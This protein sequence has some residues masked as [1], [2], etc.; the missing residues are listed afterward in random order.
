[1]TGPADRAY[2]AYREVR[3]AVLRIKAAPA[4]VAADPSAYWAEEL[5]NIDYMIEATPLVI[6]KLR[7]HAFQITGIRPYDYRDQQ[8]ARRDAFAA[9]LAA[10]VELGGADLLV[11]EHEALGGFGFELPEGLFNLDTIKYLE[12][13]VG[14]RLAGVLET[15]APATGRATVLEIGGGWG[16][17]AYQIRTLVPS[18]RYVIVD[19]PELFL[20]SA[21]YLRTVCPDAKVVLLEP[22]SPEDAVEDADIV[23]VPN[24]LAGRAAA[25]AP[26]LLLNVAS[27]Q[28]MTDAQVSAYAALAHGAGCPRLY[29]L[30]RERSGHNHE[31]TGVSGC[32]APYYDL[33]Q[34]RV[35]DT[36]YVKAMKKAPRAGSRVSDADGLGYVHLAGTRCD[37]PVDTGP[38]VGIGL[39]A[40]NRASY[41][42]RALDSLLAQSRGDFQLVVVDD[43]S[44]DDTPAIAAEYAARDP[45]VRY[46]RQDERQGMTATWRRAFEE[47]TREPSVRYFAWASDHD[48]WHPDWLAR[49]ASVLER[50]DAVL[51]H[52]LARRID[53]QGAVLPKPPRR[54][55]TAGLG[56]L[57]ARWRHVCNEVVAAGDMVYGL[58]RADAVRQA[59]VFRDVLCPDRLLMAELALQGEFRQVPEELWF[60]R[61]FGEEEGSVARQR[62][63]LFAGRAP[64]GRRLPPWAQHARLLWR[65]Y[66]AGAPDAAERRRRA[67]RVVRYAAV[68]ALKHHRKTSVHRRVGATLRAA[69]CT[70]KRTKHYTL[71]GVFYTLVYSRRAYH[72]AVFEVATF[73]RRIGLR[74]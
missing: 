2:A 14:M 55:A 22:D 30:N 39:T 48:V 73:T 8:G 59:G 44:R 65:S 34:V 57:D 72:R 23:C 21:T 47:A 26:D 58:M 18:V 68:Y 61:Q 56:D 70:W 45:R 24:T 31:L 42:R 7:H 20:F 3:D 9:R 53:E 66:V 16:G 29:S 32:L 37:G 60:R 27:F 74:G 64:R 71:L 4:E 33:E 11:P 54:F 63:S 49:L 67:R 36:D 50:S 43:G 12:V 52:P 51:V 25:Y 6:R 15:L 41:L 5:G 28:E 17:L 62:A 38:V 13:L 1:M 40:H 10:L 69:R 46:V 35:L 19:F